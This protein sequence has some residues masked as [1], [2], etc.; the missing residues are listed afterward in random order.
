MAEKKYYV[1]IQGGKD[2]NH[3]FTG[4]QP[5]KAALKAATRGFT[6]IKL[7]ER[8]TK[9]IHLFKG[10]RVKVTAPANKPS[11]MPGQIWEPR[12]KKLG[13]EKLGKKKK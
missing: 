9:K 13:I 10:Q 4:K 8:G 1:L 5:R 2:T 7:R 6:D 3:I 12:V 11:W